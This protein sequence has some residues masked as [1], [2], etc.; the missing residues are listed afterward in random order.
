MRARRT[1]RGP[2]S[3]WFLRL[4][5][6]GDGAWRSEETPGGC[7]PRLSRRLARFAQRSLDLA[8]NNDFRSD[9]C[10]L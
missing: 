9:V 2:R 6:D 5:V 1:V 3:A 7:L 4:T 8:I 10:E